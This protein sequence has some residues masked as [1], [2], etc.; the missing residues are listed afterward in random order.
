MAAAVGARSRAPA[1]TR[2][3]TAR[4]AA[5]RQLDTLARERRGKTVLAL[6]G[7]WLLDRG[8]VIALWGARRP[9]RLTP[10][11]EVMGLGLGDEAMRDLDRILA[12]R[13]KDPVLPEFMAPPP[14]RAG[15]AVSSAKKR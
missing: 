9:D 1:R 5:V 10:V 3:C 8:N 6:A 2:S 15:E 11:S 12:E 4:L 7:R 13:I 14:K